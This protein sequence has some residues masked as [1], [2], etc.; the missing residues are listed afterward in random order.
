M[1]AKVLPFGVER[2]SAVGKECIWPLSYIKFWSLVKRK[3]G[4]GLRLTHLKHPHPCEMCDTLPAFE[5]ELKDAL[6][7]LSV[8]NDSTESDKLGKDIVHIRGM[9]NRRRAHRLALDHQRPWINLNIRIKLA[10]GD[11]MVQADYVSFFNSKGKKVHDLI[12]VER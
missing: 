12:L 9:V 8:C 4:E 10:P 6:L 11:T 1:N 7:A 3:K 5:K 2:I